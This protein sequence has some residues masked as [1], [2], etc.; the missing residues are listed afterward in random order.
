MAVR[1]D[2]FER[3]CGFDEDLAVG[4]DVDLC[5]RMQLAGYRF[6][7]GEGVI[8]RREKSGTYALLRRSIQVA[9]AAQ[10]SIRDIEA[11]AFVPNLFP[12]FVLGCTWLLQVPDSLMRTSDGYGYVTLVRG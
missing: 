5:W 12:R 3:V 1:R 8:S 2:A 6:T 7:I 4:E 11:Q 9:G 10:S